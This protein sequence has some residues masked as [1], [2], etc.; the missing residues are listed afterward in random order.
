MR[1]STDVAPTRCVSIMLVFKISK[2]R[3]PK[4]IFLASNEN[5]LFMFEPPRVFALGMC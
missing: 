5:R 1:S 2:E 3:L 4:G